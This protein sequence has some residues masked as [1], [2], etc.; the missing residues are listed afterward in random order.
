MLRA[1]L[2]IDCHRWQ[3]NDCSEHQVSHIGLIS[4]VLLM[5][6]SALAVIS[7]TRT[8]SWSLYFFQDVMTYPRLASLYQ[9]VVWESLTDVHR[10]SMYLHLPLVNATEALAT[11]LVSPSDNSA[12]NICLDLAPG[13][14]SLPKIMQ[15]GCEF[16]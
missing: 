7:Q 12:L 3:E 9:V 8:S 5:N 4:F 2:H 11:S 16:R 1:Y 6:T 10:N 13:C 15:A 14:A